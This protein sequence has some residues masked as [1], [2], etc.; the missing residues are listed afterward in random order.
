MDQYKY[1]VRFFCSSNLS[2]NLVGN[3]HFFE[4]KFAVK[5]PILGETGIEDVLIDFNDGLRLQIPEGNWHVKISDHSSNFVFVDEDISEGATLISVEKFLVHWEITL[6]LNG[7]IC[8]YHQFDPHEQ[9]IHFKFPGTAIG[10]N[11][12]FFAY[13]NEFKRLYNCQVTC[14]VPKFMKDIVRLYYPEVKLVDKLPD[15]TYAT[16]Y[17]VGQNFNERFV[18]TENV[19]SM[20]LQ[21]FGQAILGWNLNVPQKVIKKRCNTSAL[22]MRNKLQ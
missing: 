7:E 16:F 14:T 20:P 4:S 21:K 13:M 3:L 8:F 11:I 17:M 19:R 22:A 5:S 9:N 6:A 18:A 1:P 12:T 2:K 10:D 15:D